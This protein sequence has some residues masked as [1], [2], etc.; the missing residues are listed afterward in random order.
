MILNIELIDNQIDQQIIYIR[1][2]LDVLEENKSK[3]VDNLK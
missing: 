3:T 2:M 1:N